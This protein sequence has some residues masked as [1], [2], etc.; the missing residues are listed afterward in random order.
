LQHFN[1][2]SAL[3]WSNTTLLT[4]DV[5]YWLYGKTGILKLAQ[6]VTSATTITVDYWYQNV[7]T[8][9]VLVNIP[10]Q[11]V[12]FSFGENA[13]GQ[14]EFFN[15]KVIG[16]F[17]NGGQ[18]GDWR[19]YFVDLPNQG[20][21]AGEN[22]KFYL[23]VTWETNLTDVDAF[24]FGKGGSNLA[25]V[26]YPESRYGP[27]LF[28]EK[29]G[30][31]E[32]TGA[33]YTTTKS[34][35]EVVLPP[36]TGGLNVIA[37][38]N[39]KMSG[40]L[41]EEKISG[42]VG[43]AY[44]NPSELKIVTNKLA[45]TRYVNLYSSRGFL[46]LNGVAAGPSAPERIR[47]ISIRQDDVSGISTND[48]FL[49]ALA[50]GDYTKKVTVKK[51]ALIFGAN[52]TSLSE[53]VEKPCVDLDLGV[54][55]DG[56][57]P[58]NI[59]DG[60]AIADELVTYDA[61]QDAEERVKIINPPVEDDPDTPG[62][63]EA[64][65]GAPYLI[66]VLGYET[67][68][69]CLFILDV[70][71][72][73]GQDL[74]VVGISQETIDPFTVA[75]IG[76]SWSLPAET[77]DGEFMG[78]FYVGPYEAP[79]ALLI[80]I[81]LILERTPPGDGDGNGQIPGEP[82]PKKV[83]FEITTSK[84]VNYMD[85]RTTN[86]PVPTI[87]ILVKDE[88]RGELDWRSVKIFLDGA[89]I[90]HHADIDIPFTDPDGRTGPKEY[91]YWE[92]T[93]TYAPPTA[94]PDKSYELRLEMKDLAGN[95]II[96]EFI[97]VIDT[98]APPLEDGKLFPSNNF[99]A[100]ESSILIHGTTE[101]FAMV[102]VKRT[103]LTADDTGYFS[104]VQD[105]EPGINDIV[106][107]T[108]DW[109]GMDLFGNLVVGNSVSKTLRI[110]RD[111]VP[112]LICGN[113]DTDTECKN[114][115]TSTGLLTNKDFSAIKGYVTD[116]IGTPGTQ[117]AWEST[118]VELVI[119]GKRVEVHNDGQFETLVPLNEGLNT[120][121]ISARD[122]AGNI[123]TR[124]INITKDITSPVLSLESIPSEVSSNKISIKGTTE[125]GSTVLINGKYVQSGGG[126]FSEDI[127]LVEGLN[128]IIIEVQDTA[129]N[130][131]TRSLSVTY[132]PSPPPIL[133]LTLPLLLLVMI[134][135]FLIGWK[136]GSHGQSRRKGEEAETEGEPET[137][138]EDETKGKIDDKG[139]SIG[140][141]IQ[142]DSK[143][144]DTKEEEMETDK[145]EKK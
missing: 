38:H 100:N 63:N 47:N 116:N 119:D 76:V 33:F 3:V 73:Q 92:C 77:L 86:D 99:R 110:I 40:N 48:D 22:M 131:E 136:I 95:Q 70:N 6:N 10:S 124:Q 140:E 105:L 27:I 18:S 96:E 49:N 50:D 129:G 139:E 126:S 112:P 39:V 4:P 106:I 14:D 144:L 98:L 141:D 102:T 123:A 46:G 61:D 35:R 64:V 28:M 142:D 143:D 125:P 130:V 81:E 57:G 108:V 42:E 56:K 74:E 7:T 67:G 133:Y 107:T 31:S 88:V 84:Q 103:N 71:L 82:P 53:N 21:F 65:V 1:V 117:Y 24:S 128:I 114:I 34:N 2:V 120:I 134:L 132:S 118:S 55:L 80:P 97:F 122:T 51:S 5:D 115:I 32:E 26:Q 93:I 36:L 66:K 79:M 11:S 17:G 127:Y 44:V 90:T 91:G 75:T 135:V 62:I 41:H 12:D 94:L 13:P 54:F 19:F 23:N 59:P 68:G 52:I 87:T 37:L 60:K 101:P 43:M 78:A 137:P 30:G 85:N 104:K 69:Q 113:M 45:D 111:E 25:G 16:G 72:V 83:G 29:K 145:E 9:P 20:L 8:I 58:N 15:N 121:I 109:Y 138:T 89:D